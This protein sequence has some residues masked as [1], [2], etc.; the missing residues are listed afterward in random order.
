MKTGPGMAQFAQVRQVCLGSQMQTQSRSQV[1]CSALF[2]EQCIPTRTPEPRDTLSL[3]EQ[4]L[5]I[6]PDTCILYHRLLPLLEALVES[7]QLNP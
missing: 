2:L 3:P 5:R 1:C 4:A 7:S 6:A